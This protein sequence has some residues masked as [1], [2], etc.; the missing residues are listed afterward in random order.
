MRRANLY[1]FGTGEVHPRIHAKL[2]T[3]GFGRPAN[4]ASHLVVARFALGVN[5]CPILLAVPLPM[6]SFTSLEHA[7]VWV[8]QSVLEF[9]WVAPSSAVLGMSAEKS[10]VSEIFGAELVAVQSE[11]CVACRTSVVAEST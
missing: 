2:L 3:A 4:A 10:V 6:G 9:P 1:L 8:D 5:Y 11:S 7:T